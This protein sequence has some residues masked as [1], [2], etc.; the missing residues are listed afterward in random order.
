MMGRHSIFEPYCAVGEP[1]MGEKFI[2]GSLFFMPSACVRRSAF[3]SALS[4]NSRT[5]EDKL[6]CCRVDLHPGFS[7]HR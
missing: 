6:A 4:T 7:D 2:R 5:A 3:G 1:R